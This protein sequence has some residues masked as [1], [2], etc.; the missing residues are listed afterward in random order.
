MFANGAATATLS[1]LFTPAGASSPLSVSGSEN[2]LSTLGDIAGKI[3]N[4]PNTI[5]GNVIGGI[6]HVVGE[7]GNFLDLYSPEPTIG[8]AN[9]AIEFRNNPL[10]LRNG[11]ITFGNSIIYGSNAYSTA[12]HERVHTYQGQFLGPLYL[13][14]NI[15]GMT[16]SA[17][18][19]PI[20]SLRR[21]DLLHGKL[22]FMEGSPSSN[23]LYGY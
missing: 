12:P 13:P 14:A 2:A 6:G 21:I 9:N 15:L 3:W 11:A 10:M 5:L 7:I 16:A 8:F 19:Y 22:N 17:L 20:S 1:A 23:K 4:L 18:S